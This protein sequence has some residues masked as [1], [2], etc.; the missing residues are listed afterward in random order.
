MAK[1]SSVR[2]GKGQVRRLGL[3]HTSPYIG[4]ITSKDVLN[5]TG[6]STQYSIITS[7]GEES[8]KMGYISNR[9]TS[10]LYI[11]S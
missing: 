5:G 10:L 4:Q 6:N 11:Q 2:W 3:A 7:M 9:I 1:H 8:G